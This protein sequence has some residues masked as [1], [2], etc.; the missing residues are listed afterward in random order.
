MA[1]GRDV[2]IGERFRPAGR[3]AFGHPSGDVFEVS[4]IRVDGCIVPHALLV[5]IAD[6]VDHRLISVDALRDHNLYLPVEFQSVESVVQ[7]AQEWRR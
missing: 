7:L 1:E 4:G 3:T 2:Q 6:T 5:N